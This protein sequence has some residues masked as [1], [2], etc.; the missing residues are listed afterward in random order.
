[1][2]KYIAIVAIVFGLAFAMPTEKVAKAGGCTA[3]SCCGC[4]GWHP[5][6]NM[7]ARAEARRARRN[8]CGCTG[9]EHG[10]A[11][12]VAPAAADASTPEVTDTAAVDAE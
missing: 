3:P 6:A 4:H 11:I 8:C 10:G 5:L 9:H 7:H 1:M 12:I 2:F